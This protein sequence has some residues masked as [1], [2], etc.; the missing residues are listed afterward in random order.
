[1]SFARKTQNQGLRV[2]QHPRSPNFQT[3]CVQAV[4]V[5]GSL[6]LLDRSG[7][8]LCGAVRQ[9]DLGESR[10]LFVLNAWRWS[11]AIDRM[12]VRIK[13]QIDNQ[14]VDPWTRRAGSLAQSLRIRKRFA[15]PVP[16]SRRRF[17]A[18]TTATWPEAAKRLWQQG[19]NRRRRHERTGW[20]RWAHT[21]ANNH[22]KRKGGCY[23][24]DLASNH[25]PNTR[26][27]AIATASVRD[28]RS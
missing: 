19:N 18:Y 20:V 23:A 25:K 16:S 1:M 3:V 5:N 7:K 15:R 22:N 9:S 8:R 28:Q 27:G 21:V 10:N 2:N 17:E 26:D 24:K 12:K 6:M 14:T 13:R 11:F 4:E